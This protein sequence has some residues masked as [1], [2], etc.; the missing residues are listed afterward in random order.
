MIAYDNFTFKC[1]ILFYVFLRLS[2]IITIALFPCPYLTL[3]PTRPI[4]QINRAQLPLPDY[5]SLP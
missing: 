3:L 5:D 4:E 2:I 1:I